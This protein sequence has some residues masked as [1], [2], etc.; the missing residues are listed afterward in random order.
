MVNT[1][2]NLATNIRIC[3]LH[4]AYR[5]LN[6]N[7]IRKNIRF[8]LYGVFLGF[9]GF[10]GHKAHSVRV[11]DQCITGNSG[12]ALIGFGKAAVNNQQLPA[13]FNGCLPFFQFHRHMS[14]DDMAL[15]LIQAELPQNPV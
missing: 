15:C 8:F 6:H 3:H 10:M 12:L 11:G 9:E 13:T 1:L 2:N 4:P 7:R 5:P 14:V